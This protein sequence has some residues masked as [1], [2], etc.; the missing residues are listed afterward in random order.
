MWEPRL[1]ESGRAWPFPAGPHSPGDFEKDRTDWRTTASYYLYGHAA[2]I[3]P[4]LIGE[5]SGRFPFLEA[6]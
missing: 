2:Y 6:L 3:N 1:L 4:L 5:K